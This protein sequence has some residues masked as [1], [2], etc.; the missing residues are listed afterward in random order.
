[1]RL[2]LTF[3]VAVAGGLLW[4]GARV[5]AVTTIPVKSTAPATVFLDLPNPALAPVTAAGSVTWTTSGG[6]LLNTWNV[7]I[8]STA[9]ATL[10]TNCPEIPISAVTV[11]CT[12]V[13]GGLGGTCGAVATL[14][15]VPQQIAN[16]LESVGAYSSTV[17]VTFAITDAWKYKGHTTTPCTLNVTYTI[18]AN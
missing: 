12:S 15:T 7:Q 3:A 17:N 8:S 5:V 11:T 16:G 9:A 18:T 4:S 13:T 14:T 1:M 10:F 2:R 6:F